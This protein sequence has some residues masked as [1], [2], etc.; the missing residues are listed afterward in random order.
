MLAYTMLYFIIIWGIENLKTITYL[1]SYNFLSAI[2]ILGKLNIFKS[3]NTK[4]L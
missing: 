4:S 2:Y 1:P 3:Q